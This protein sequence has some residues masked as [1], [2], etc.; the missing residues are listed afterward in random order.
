MKKNKKIKKYIIM[1]S[2]LLLIVIA[3]IAVIIINSNKT[4]ESTLNT[5]IVQK[6]AS[7]QTIQ[8][9][10]TGSGQIVTSETEKISLT[11]TKY[12]ES[13]CVEED[14]TL[15]EGENI[16]EYSDGTYLTA[17]YD[18]I[19]D[20]YSVPETESKCTSSNYVQI[21]NI[22]KLNMTLS[23]NE[24]EINSVSVGQS[25]TITVNAVENKT[26]TGTISKIDAIGTYSTSGSTFTATIEFENDG[27]VKIGMSASC[28]II[29]EEAKDCIAVP[30]A[31]IQTSG[32]SKYVIV[33]KDD[34]TTENV[35]V[36][37]GISNDSYVQIKSGL[38][39]TETV[40]MIETTSTN[41]R[42][43]SKTTSSTSTQSGMQGMMGMPSEMSSSI[44]GEVPSGMQRPTN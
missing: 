38:T 20:T 8:K 14:D 27:N 31:A 37:T 2:I 7:T 18:C 24:S 43:F 34:G 17:P 44:G 26:Y 19:I 32:N 11:T 42:S 22:A 23:I 29:L 5:A 39:G 25:V 16:L 33:V 6:Q 9:T 3:I 35:T 40:Q 28:S 13:M 4:K 41:T 36:E 1:G 21:K 30:I 12:F 15:K 10:L